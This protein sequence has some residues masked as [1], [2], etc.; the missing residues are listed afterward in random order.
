MDGIYCLL[1]DKVPKELIEAAGDKLKVVSTMSAGFNHVDVDT[2][3]SKSIRVGHTP[4]ALTET[5]ADLAVGL[6]LATARRIPEA[7]AAVKKGEWTTWK[8][9]WLTGPDVFGSTVGIVGM[10]RIGTEIAK[11]LGRGFGCKILYSGGSGPKPAAEE[12]AGGAQYRE[13]DA[14]LEESRFVI[15][16]CALNDKTR[17]LISSAQLAKMGPEAIL[18]NV[19][20]GEI[21]DQE[22]LIKALQDG[23]IAAAG[24]DVTTPEPLPVASPLLT[25]PNCVVL[26]HI[27]SA[28]VPTRE[29]IA[30]MA[31]ENLVAGLEGKDLPYGVKGT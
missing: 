24:L 29:T 7:A 19:G 25:L 1:S 10:G 11:R 23:T 22:A 17:H 14:L 8:P 4:D 5:T 31:V 27:G 6:L 26:P 28:S 12:A 30:K 9:M 16:A 2:C 21:V 18:V 20:R 13:L 3:K 15:V